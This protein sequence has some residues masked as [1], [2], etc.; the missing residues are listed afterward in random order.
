MFMAVTWGAIMLLRVMQPKTWL[1]FRL[2]LLKT[3]A[4]VTHLSKLKEMKSISPAVQ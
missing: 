3:L 4:A 2:V 1:I